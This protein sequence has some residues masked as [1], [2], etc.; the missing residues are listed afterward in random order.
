MRCN[1]IKETQKVRKELNDDDLLR[2]SRQILIPTFDISGQQA[3]LEACVLVVGAG[4]LGCAASQYLVAAGLGQLVLA[5]SDTVDLANLQRQVLY[6][7]ADIGEFKVLAAKR[8]LNALN[9]RCEITAL[10]VNLDEYTLNEPGDRYQLIIDCSDNLT[11]RNLLNRLSLKR[12]IPLISGAAIRMEG[13]L[14]TFQPGVGESCYQCFSALFGEQQLRCVESGILSPVVGIIGNLQALEAIKLLCNLGE[15]SL[16]IL[17][18]YD[19][20]SGHW[21]HFH[22]PRR[23]NCP[24]CQ[25]RS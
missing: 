5:D 13:Q 17:Q 2:Y 21:Q 11:T 24:A 19:A 20:V 16:D 1:N 10:P 15:P 7:E 18:T 23:A 3:L 8:N 6:R 9:S 4:G 25:S 12:Q 22:I 14:A